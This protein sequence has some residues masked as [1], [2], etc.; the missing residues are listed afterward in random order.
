MHG[1]V[2]LPASAAL[3]E[4]RDDADAIDLRQLQ[5]FFW[6]RWKLVGMTMIAVMVLTLLALFTVTPR[7]TA[8][9]QVL[10]HPQQ[11]KVFG[12]QDI[13]PEL[14]LESGNVDSQVTVIQ[15]IS[16]LRRVVER[17]KLTDDAEFGQPA[18][19]GLMHML[20]G[21][22]VGDENPP[23]APEAKADAASAPSATLRSIRRLRSALDVQ[24]VNRTYVLSISVTSEDPLR[25]ERLADAVADAYVVDQLDSRY[26]SAKR[27]SAWLAERMD[28]LR[29]Q[30]HDAEEAVVA[31]R[32]E[33]NIQSTSADSKVTI[34]EQQMSEL[35]AKLATA[36]ADAAEKRA[37]YEQARDMQAERGDLQAIPDVV[38]S[39]VISQLRTQEA[40]VTRNEADLVSRYSDQHPLVINARAQRR[41]IE[42]S[43]AAE[44]ARIISN[45]KNDYDVAKTGEESLQA[46]LSLLTG[47]SGP[48][49]DVGLR[50]R[51]LE[52]T[53]TAN[54]SLYEDFLS[55]AKLTAEESTLQ[56]GEARLISPATKPG[57]PSFP[58]FSLVE[59]LSGV[60]GLLIGVAGAVALDMLNAGFTT[61]RE[62]EENLGLPVLASV[63]LLSDRDRVFAGKAL[64][65]SRYL[66]AKPLSRFAEAVRAI[67]VGVQMADVDHPAKVIL[68]TS[69]IPQEG[70]TTLAV[71]LAFSAVKAGLKVLLIDCDLRHPS[72]T[73]YFGLEQAKGLVDFLTGAA[74]MEE[75]IKTISGMVVL[76]AGAKS[77]NPPDLLGSE[78]MRHLI[79][80]MRGAFDYTVIDSPP[81]GPVIDAR[82]LASL[83][84]K[85]I[86]VVRWSST[87]RE[88]VAQNLDPL[89]KDRKIAGIALNLVDE[90]K[91]PRYGPYSHYSGYYYKKYYQ[92]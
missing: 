89:I 5:D 20:I 21:Y 76:P 91:T 70:K 67:R 3:N 22:F 1:R 38:R 62:V 75:A 60:V 63:P 47:Q 7:Y 36:R 84:D 82:V 12:A 30:V 23:N 4:L 49:N 37:K 50:L 51:E 39:T 44:V 48:D 14:S 74:P 54:R 6:R 19:P 77:Q 83:V 58:S 78:R 41:D 32:R 92:N 57:A 52:R 42:K 53:A 10:L 79:E 17:E 27:A 80:Q 35:N 90:T 81:V 45:L 68:L 31:F 55:R 25:A 43:I 65:P 46:S 33:H 13:L 29:G 18:R 64:D 61:S 15:S 59:T 34:G 56:E 28:G 26:D 9:A 24:R 86:F 66:I 2:S 69:S 11:G 72:V 73:R 85:V 40:E 88:L 16:L 71:S 87:T 8:T